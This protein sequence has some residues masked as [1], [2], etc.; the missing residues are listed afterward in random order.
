VFTGR[1]LSAE[2]ETAEGIEFFKQGME[3]FA[4]EPS[5]QDLGSVVRSLLSEWARVFAR[6]GDHETAAVLLGADDA[7]YT[8]GIVRYSYMQ[9]RYDEVAAWIV[10]AIGQEAFE[11]ARD[12]GRALTFPEAVQYG[13]RA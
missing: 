5:Y 7:S 12:R 11:A 3:R 10:E 4:R 9:A 13:L 1:L 6:S 8:G 2:G